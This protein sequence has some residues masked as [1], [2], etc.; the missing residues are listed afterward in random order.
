[1]A[2]D[3]RP[4]ILA[5]FTDAKVSGTGKYKTEYVEIHIRDRNP[6]LHRGHKSSKGVI[7]LDPP[8]MLPPTEKSMGGKVINQAVRIPCQLFVPIDCGISHQ[9]DTFINDIV[10]SFEEIIFANQLTTITNGV[11]D[12]QGCM[13]VPSKSGD[14]IRRLIYIRARKY[15][16]FSS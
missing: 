4:E 16:D 7:S 9:V 1:M 8:T 2:F 11:I 3:P 5:K 6:T 12:F 10:H 14:N 13:P 15:E